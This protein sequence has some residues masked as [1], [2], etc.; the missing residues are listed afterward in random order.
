[1]PKLEWV[2]LADDV[3]CARALCG[4]LRVEAVAYAILV[5]G[6]PPSMFPKGTDG[7]TFQIPGGFRA[8]YASYPTL[9]AAQEGAELALLNTLKEDVRILEGGR[10]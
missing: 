7:Y 2:K 8:T 5:Y 3:W 9:E 6:I 1:M 10:A 4:E